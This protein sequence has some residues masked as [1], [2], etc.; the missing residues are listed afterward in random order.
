MGICL[1][2]GSICKDKSSAIN[3]HR[4][5]GI[6]NQFT[7]Q[8]NTK[9]KF[10]PKYNIQ[11]IGYKIKITLVLFCDNNTLKNSFTYK[12]QLYIDN[13][14]LEEENYIFLGSTEAIICQNKIKFNKS[15]ETN[16]FFSKGQRIKICCL[17]NEKNISVS[18]F[19]LGKMI[20]GFEN[21][22]LKIEKENTTVGELLILINKEENSKL[23][24]NKKCFFS[25]ELLDKSK[26]TDNENYF[27][28][29]INGNN[30]I[31][32]KSK[33]FK[34]RDNNNNNNN[35]NIDY[36]FNFEIR[37]HFIFYSNKSIRFNLYSIKN[38][39]NHNVRYNDNND[40]NNQN[41]DNNDC[42]EN[43]NKNL[44]ENDNLNSNNNKEYELI[45]SIDI[46]EEELL[47]NN[48]INSFKLRKGILSSLFKESVLI[49]ISYKESEYTPFLEY[50]RFQLHLNLMLIFNDNILKN[51]FTQIKNIVT[52]FFSI[53][54][55]YDTED[56]KIIFIKT[57]ENHSIE[58][59]NNIKECLEFKKDK[60]EENI[61]KDKNEE[62]KIF[63]VIET[64]KN[65][66]LLELNKGMN[67]YFI[68][69][70]FTDNK[71][72]D[73]NDNEIELN[74]N[75]L[76]YREY[77]HIPLNFKIFNL[78]E[79]NYFNETNDVNM[80]IIYKNNGDIK[81]ERKIFQYYNI[82]NQN[83]KKEKGNKYLNDIPFL[84]EDFFE[85]QKTSKFSI[86]E[87]Q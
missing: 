34:D 59:A 16:Y 83:N 7:V 72:S 33:E 21:P 41:E 68:V 17:E 32:Y 19:Y 6:E 87:E 27:F 64:L 50:I 42:K 10:F 86:F 26:I 69:L 24:K 70:I 77:E 49:K 11:D 51:K 5:I 15:F 57:D 65:Y 40:N 23:F 52:Y 3:V 63:P 13:S 12:F 2:P 56:K 1:S 20:N 43:N 80:N 84:I 22:K 55:L 8:A 66:M 75:S 62:N 14:D 18:S 47:Q 73:V 44:N 71:F 30:E 60:I 45:G 53:L 25:I 82:N 37:K 36:M 31:I 9:E 29:I 54:S 79:E 67:K 81:Y 35:E 76:I 78:G 58:K 4:S 85:I 61:V 46:S 28:C 74:N 38:H 48:G 39:N